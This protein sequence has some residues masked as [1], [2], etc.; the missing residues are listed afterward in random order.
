MASEKAE[1]PYTAP[2]EQPTKSSSTRRKRVLIYTWVA[3]LVLLIRLPSVLQFFHTGNGSQWMSKHRESPKSHC[4]QVDPLFPE[5]TTSKLK[6]MEDFVSSGTFQNQSIARLSGAVQIPSMS[7]DDLGEIG[8]DKRWDIFYKF[9]SYLEDTFPCDLK[10]TLLM[11]HQDVV[12]VPDST[13]DAWT[14]PPFS[15]YYD[16]KYI[17]GRGSSD[18]KNQLIAIMETVELLLAADFKPNRTVVLSFGFDEE[19][20]GREGAGHLAPFLLERYGK[21]AFAAIVD[22]GMGVENKWGTDYAAP[23]VAEKGYTDV[24]ITIRMP[25][26]H[27]SVPSWH[28]SIGVLSEFITLIEAHPF[29][30]RLDDK[31]PFLG[32]LQCGAEYSPDFPS[33]LRKLLHKRS[34]PHNT[35]SKKGDPLAEAAAAEDLFSRYLVQTSQAVDV[36]S[37]GA[38]VNALPERASA[39]VNHRVNIGERPRDVHAKLT[40]LAKHV[41]AKYNLT[42]HAFDDAAE[43]PSSIMLSASNTTLEPAPVTPTTLRSDN[44]VLSPYGVLSGTLRALYGEDMLVAPG[45]MTGNTDTRYYWD[46]SRHIFRFGPGYEKGNKDG[47]SGIHTVDERVSVVA[48]INAVKWFGMFIRNMDEAK[49]G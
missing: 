28:T 14:H 34:K 37:G 26:G 47:L 6:E 49:M 42:V 27:S 25:G 3:V 31:N 17:W 24:T 39:I 32:Q 38:K 43:A 23:A 7:F 16:G 45:I 19:I 22:E 10:P 29:T 20:S 36:I 30:P 15:G 46:L 41:G 2:A 35:C 13:I 21:D 9:E 5:Q 11:A 44:G 40:R 48:H 1:L 33:K 8:E 4:A 12:P 18:C